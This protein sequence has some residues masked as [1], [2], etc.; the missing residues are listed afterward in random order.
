M[1]NPFHSLRHDVL[2]PAQ[3]RELVAG[4]LDAPFFGPSALGVEFIRTDG[5]SLVFQRCHIEAVI[6]QFPYLEALL[7]EALFE[8]CNA[9]YINPLVLYERSAVE[10]HVDCRMTNQGQRLIP[11]IVSVYYAQVD[12]DM[13]G[14]R[15]VFHPGREDELPLLP[16]TGDLLH[17]VGTTIHA[18]EPV[19]AR[20]NRISVVCEQYHLPDELLEA[21]P[22]CEIL[23]GNASLMRANAH[24]P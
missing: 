1:A 22:A 10:A 18:V 15:I 6:R 12:P 9:F 23:T 16:R 20:D 11:N 3:R 7:Q 5:F 17:F 19:R 4:I 13:A 2:S 24:Q 8:Q 21:F 14:G